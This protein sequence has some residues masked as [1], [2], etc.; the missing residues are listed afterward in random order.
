[1]CIAET[2]LCIVQQLNYNRFSIKSQTSEKKK[3]IWTTNIVIPSPKKLNSIDYDYF[4]V[5]LWSFNEI[6]FL[7]KES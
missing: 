3:C 4:S 6:V 2:C 5:L 1:M 7:F